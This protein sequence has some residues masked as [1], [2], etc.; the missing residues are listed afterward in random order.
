MDALRVAGAS[1]ELL[2]DIAVH[3]PASRYA[4]ALNEAVWQG[5]TQA[6]I[7]DALDPPKAAFLAAARASL[8]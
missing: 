7:A 3:E 5:T 4:R 1:V 6:P 2:C 8:T